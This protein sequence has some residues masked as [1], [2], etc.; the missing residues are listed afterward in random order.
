LGT[1]NTIVFAQ[2]ALGLFRVFATG[3]SPERIA[4]PKSSSQEQAYASPLF[5]PGGRAVLY[6]AVLTDGSTR[7]V[8][9]RFG[10]PDA[11]TVVEGG[12]GPHY[13][14]AGYLVYGDAD[15]VVG[16][17]F[18]MATLRIIGSPAVLQDRVLAKV[19]DRVID[20]A[21]ANTGTVVFV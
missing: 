2:G 1:R 5:L 12:F 21:T 10:A 7:I 17:R 14:T 8:S 16:A 18:D 4:A 20:I 13:L 15:R 6:T 19:A 11:A 9:R 3:G